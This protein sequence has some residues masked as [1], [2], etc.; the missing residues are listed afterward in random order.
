MHDPMVL[1]I[2]P[3]LD[4]VLDRIVP[5]PVD[6]VWMAWTTPE[7]L[8]KFF[9]PRPWQITHCELDTRPGGIFSTTMRSPEGE[10]YPNSGCFLEVI[11][12]RRLTWTSALKPGFRPAR[13]GRLPLHRHP[14]ALPPGRKH[15]LPGDRDAHPHR[16]PRRARGDG[17]RARLGNG[18]RPDGRT[19][20]EV[21]P[22]RRSVA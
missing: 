12:N 3:E 17:L 4:L 8:K 14:V 15:P 19:L 1:E 16:R 22:A 9:V 10:E 2:N 6:Y 13:S 7:H 21:T 5:V 20:R 18:R 11:P